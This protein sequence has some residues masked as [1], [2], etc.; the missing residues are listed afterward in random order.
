MKSDSACSS[1]SGVPFSGP[2]IQEVVQSIF[3]HPAVVASLSCPLDCKKE[4]AFEDVVGTLDMLISLSRQRVHM[5]DLHL[6]NILTTAS[7]YLLTLCN[8]QNSVPKDNKSSYKQLVGAFNALVQR[9]FLEARESLICA[10]VLK[11]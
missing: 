2:D 7:E 10:F 6:L 1:K 8:V 11:T 9:L 3:C 4:L 5:L